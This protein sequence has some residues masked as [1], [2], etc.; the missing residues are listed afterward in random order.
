MSTEEDD[1]KRKAIEHDARALAQRAARQG[2]AATVVRTGTTTIVTVGRRQTAE[3]R[4]QIS[5]QLQESW[6]EAIKALTAEQIFP[7]L[8]RV[9]FM[10]GK[11]AVLETGLRISEQREELRPRVDDALRSLGLDKA[12]QRAQL[13]Y[14][15]RIWKQILGPALTIDHLE[16]AVPVLRLKAPGVLA[17]WTLRVKKRRPDLWPALFEILNH[18]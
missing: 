5:Q 9:L 18:E 6:E 7:S 16:K 4:R 3:Q 10:H 11:K 15:D 2:R 8:K 17:A 12:W 14:I 1:W 13:D